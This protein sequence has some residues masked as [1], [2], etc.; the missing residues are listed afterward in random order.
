MT[1]FLLLIFGFYLST[2]VTIATLS[3]SRKLINVFP[4]ICE[5]GTCK[6]VIFAD[7]A[8]LFFNIP[9]SVFGCIYYVMLGL[10]FYVQ[11]SVIY[12]FLLTILPFLSSLY[13]LYRLF[14]VHNVICNIC[15]CSHIVNIGLFSYFL[16]E[17]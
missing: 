17:I 10:G 2:F 11:L 14:F 8:R 12:L 7:N 4:S 13:L 5:N 3:N 1:L 16:Y 9:N 6:Q 15:I